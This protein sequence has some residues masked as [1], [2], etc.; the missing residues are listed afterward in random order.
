M[1]SFEE[2][3]QLIRVIKNLKH[4][5]IMII[6]YSAGLRISEVVRLKLADVDMERKLIHVRQAKGRKD[7]YTTLSGIAISVLEVY[8][9]KYRPEIWLF[10]GADPEKHLSTR[11]VQKIIEA[12]CENAGLIKKVTPHTLRHS[13][14]THLLEGGT[15]LRIIQELLGHESSKTTEIY[16]HVSQKELGRVQSPLDCLAKD[17]NDFLR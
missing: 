9:E 13:F 3:S 16:T 17:E 14:A 2:F 11:T 10:P 5:V 7:R 8:L 6:T 15:D 4:R 1:I 12:A